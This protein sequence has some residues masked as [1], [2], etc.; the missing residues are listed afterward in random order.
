[1]ITSRRRDLIGSPDLHCRAD[2]APE[3]ARRLVDLFLSARDEVAFVELYRACTPY[4]LLLSRRLLGG[5]AD[6]EDAIQETWI[7]AIRALPAF[8]WDSSLRTWLAG[9]AINCSRELLRRR[10]KSRSVNAAGEAETD[11]VPLS[12]ASGV[13]LLLRALPE[14]CREVLVLHDLEGYTHE[15]IAALLGID[16][17][18]SKS[19]LSRARSRLRAQLD[20]QRTPAER[21]RHARSRE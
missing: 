10:A 2:P 14:G 1:M 11:A 3:E 4:L 5:A 17:G 7:R 9:I 13:E 18:T 15:E 6:A 20:A 8:R 12:G 16:A 21:S 19:Q